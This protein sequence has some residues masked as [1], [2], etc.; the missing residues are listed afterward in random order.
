MQF[1]F[2]IVGAQSFLRHDCAFREFHAAGPGQG[3]PDSRHLTGSQQFG[4]LPGITQS[5][6][7]R[8]GLVQLLPFCLGELQDAGRLPARLDELLFRGGYPPLCDRELAP[9]DWYANYFST[10][11]ERDVRQLLTV[12]D[13]SAFQRFLKMCAARVGQSLNVSTLAADCGVAHNTAV[14]W[15]S[16]LE[17]SYLIFLLRPHFQN[18]NKRLVKTP[19]LYF[20]DPGLAGWLLGI[21]EPAQT[22]GADFFRSLDRWN[23]LAGRAGKPAWLVYGGDLELRHGNV[24]IIPWQALPELARGLG[25]LG[26]FPG[27]SAP[28]NASGAGQACPGDR[29]ESPGDRGAGAPDSRSEKASI[30]SL[31]G[32]GC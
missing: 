31:T 27:Y 30:P 17:A 15:L 21:R 18:F 3:L 25:Q 23:E 2:K 4:L 16:V 1:N 9:L 8:V 22:I 11:V 28:G 13:L 26:S 7:G 10:Y 29:G 6:A 19:K 12:R 14:A 5:L 24:A 32:L 20:I